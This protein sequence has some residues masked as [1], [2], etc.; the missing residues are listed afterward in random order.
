MSKTKTGRP[1]NPPRP[2]ESQLWCALAAQAWFHYDRKYRDAD[3]AYIKD[4][5]A[6]E[7]P[8]VRALRHRLSRLLGTGRQGSP[9]TRR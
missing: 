1:R 2:W 5:H 7:H 6:K 9:G 4:M 8:H 3:A